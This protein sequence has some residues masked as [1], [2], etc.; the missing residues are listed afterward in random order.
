MSLKFTTHYT[1]LLRH[2]P[3]SDRLQQFYRPPINCCYKKNALILKAE[4]TS[5]LLS[6]FF[7]TI[8][9]FLL[10]YFCF[11]PFLFHTYTYQA[12]QAHVNICDPHKCKKCNNIS[13]PIIVEQVI[14]GNGQEEQSYI[15]AK[16]IFA[17]KYIKQF[18]LQHACTFFRFF[19]TEISWLTE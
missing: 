1:L 5:N 11:Y 3:L 18:S 14:P 16:A 12:K 19:H 2:L 6:L 4:I 9:Q 17:G 10:F 13:P 8:L 7:L 15:M